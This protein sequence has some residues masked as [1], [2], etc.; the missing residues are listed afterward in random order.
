MQEPS[1]KIKDRMLIASELFYYS[2]KFQNQIFILVV[3]NETELSIIFQDIYLIQSAGIK[4]IILISE[5]QSEYKELEFFTNLHRKSKLVKVHS[6]VFEKKDYTEVNTALSNNLLAIVCLKKFQENEDKF[7]TKTIKLVNYYNAIKLLFLGIFE[8]I[9]VEARVK[10]RIGPCDLS[11]YGERYAFLENIYNQ[12]PKN[13]SLV[14]LPS[15][16]GVLYREVFTHSGSGTEIS[17]KDNMILRKPTIDEVEQIYY[18]MLPYIEENLILPVNLEEIYQ[19]IDSYYVM[20]V[21]NSIV[22]SLKINYFQEACEI[23]KVCT[24]PRYRDKS[25]TKDFVKELLKI[26]KN[27]NKKYCFA[28]TINEAA[29]KMFLAIGFE[30]VSRDDLPSEWKKNYDFN[31]PSVAFKCEL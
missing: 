1:S 19:Q 21:N 2:L 3:K 23:A 5:Y 29:K 17:E 11:A 24:L 14:L 13:V 10:E 30:E 26:L 28:L 16:E 4:M 20:G 31:R 22:A 9:Y 18:M 25:L 15:E 7:F 8:P 6:F 27:S 12:I